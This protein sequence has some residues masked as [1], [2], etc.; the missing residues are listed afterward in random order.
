MRLWMSMS[1]TS[2]WDYESASLYLTCQMRALA[3]GENKIR[4]EVATT[5]ERQMGGPDPYGRQDAE[6]GGIQARFEIYSL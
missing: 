5:L 3:A 1:T 2:I 4:I 6:T